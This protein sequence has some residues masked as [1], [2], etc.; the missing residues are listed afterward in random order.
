MYGA[1]Y[2]HAP[3]PNLTGEEF[4]WVDYH[5]TGTPEEYRAKVYG[6]NPIKVSVE[7]LETRHKAWDIRSAYA[8]AWTL[9]F[10]QIVDTNVTPQYLGVDT[11]SKVPGVSE[12]RLDTS[13]LDVIINTIPLRSLCYQTDRH[14]FHSM[15]A[16]AIGD[17]PE[18]GVFAPFGPEP[19]T[20]ECDGTRDR[21]WYRSSNVF[22]YKTVEWPAQSK[23]PIPGVAPI[24]KPLYSDCDCY[25]DDINFI[26][27]GRYGQW[28]KG[29]LSHEAYTQAAQL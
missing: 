22:G 28:A 17:A 15:D 9:Y 21:G 23:P 5:L 10:D 1:Q 26:S 2:L 29:V 8:V 27:L 13:Q 6:S 24:E 25:R 18:R 7:T 14:Q 20:V 12:I 19:F 11:W 16:W 3:I 4:E